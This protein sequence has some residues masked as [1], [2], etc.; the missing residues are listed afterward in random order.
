MKWACEYN[1]ILSQLL[2]SAGVETGEHHESFVL[3]TCWAGRFLLL[4]LFDNA[5]A[6]QYNITLDSNENRT[7]PSWTGSSW[8]GPSWLY[9]SQKFTCSATFSLS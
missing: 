9:G 6:Q 4:W 8:T 5:A 1:P 3:S 2:L 7:G